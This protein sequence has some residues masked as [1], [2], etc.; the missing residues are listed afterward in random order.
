MYF[1]RGNTSKYIYRQRLLQNKSKYGY[2]FD[3]EKH[4]YFPSH[5]SVHTVVSVVN[6][7]FSLGRTQSRKGKSL[8]LFCFFLLENFFMTRNVIEKKSLILTFKFLTN[9]LFDNIRLINTDLNVVTF[10]ERHIY[11]RRKPFD[12]RFM[13][14]NIETIINSS[15]FFISIL[16]RNL[17]N[18]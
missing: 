18:C 13:R 11:W 16:K 12:E 8:I 10:D 17:I 2:G 6:W 14:W 1:C 5:R 15:I 4:P 9:D 7:S 3:S